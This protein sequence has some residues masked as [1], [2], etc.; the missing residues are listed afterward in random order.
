[1]NLSVWD[2]FRDMEDLLERYGRNRRRLPSDGGKSENMAVADWH[3]LVDISETDEEYRVHA[4]LPGVDKED[5]K[6]SVDDGV[7]TVQ[8]S[9]EIKKEEEDKERKFHRIERS[10]GSFSRSFSLPDNADLENISADCKDGVLDVGIPKLQEPKK[11]GIEV[12]VK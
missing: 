9:R 10:Y 1:M 2:P 7:L 11:R 12:D 4:E 8:G 5:I 3:P 6:V